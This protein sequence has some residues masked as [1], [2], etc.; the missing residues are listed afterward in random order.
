MGIRPLTSEDAP[1]M[2]ALMARRREEYERYSPVF[3]RRASDV[4]ELHAR[5]LR[6]LVEDPDNIGLRTDRGFVTAVRRGE[7]YYADDFA[8]ERDGSWEVD[9]RV[10]L[11]AVWSDA[12]RRDASALRVV[13]AARD[14][15]KVAM[16]RG[17]G[18]AVDVRWWVKP[19]DVSA[20]GTA[21][22]GTVDGEGFD[23]T[24]TAAPPVY[25]PGGPVVIVNRVDSAVAL[26]R[27]EEKS[28]DLGAVLVIL[29]IEPSSSKQEEAARTRGYE[30]ASEFYVGRPL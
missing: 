7:Q 19:L 29:P 16:L 24:L 12:K 22:S 14:V 4:E 11:L 3:W 1:W 23:A 17:A 6:R 20:P 13:T 5:F 8:L 28:R 9:G 27:A 2:A 18:M 26:E 10:L 30:V 21:Y 25:N 15:A